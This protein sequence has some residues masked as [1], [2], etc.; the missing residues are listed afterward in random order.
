MKL[1]IQGK[2]VLIF[3]NGI[4]MDGEENPEAQADRLL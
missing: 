2:S 3:D 1:S 4:G